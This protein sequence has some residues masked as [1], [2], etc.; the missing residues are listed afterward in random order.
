MTQLIVPIFE[1]DKKFYNVE[2][3][4]EMTEKKVFFF[5]QNFPPIFRVNVD[6][7]V[8]RGA[9]VMQLFTSVIYKFS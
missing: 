4:I 3:W 9:N 1:F 5:S 6:F 8:T 7:I 2:N